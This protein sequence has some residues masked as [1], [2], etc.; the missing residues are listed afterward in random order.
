MLQRYRGEI[1]GFGTSSGHRIVIG[2]WEDSPFGSFAD[3]MVESPSGRR[4]LL[5]PSDEVAELVSTTYT[6]DETC[7]VAVRAERS[8]D[9]L[10][11]EAGP[12]RVRVRFGP[13]TALGRILRVVPRAVAESRA[14]CTVA[15]PVARVVLRGVRTRGSA[16]NDRT[17]FYGATDQRAVVSVDASWD[18]DDLGSLADVWPPVRFGFSSTP[19]R[20]S[21]VST[22]TTITSR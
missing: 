18:G 17:E 4:T 21:V 16:G 9:G 12:L 2:R 10:D 3:V 8:A 22:T 15:D 6:F 11:C 7:V 1:A 13:R 5:A 20:P 19:R 14:W